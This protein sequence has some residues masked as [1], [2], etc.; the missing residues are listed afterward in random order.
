L[1][2]YHP[3]PIDTSGVQ[4]DASLL[5]LTE[6]LARN[7]HEVWAEG[8]IHQGWTLGEKRDD[9]ARTHPD[10]IPYESLRESEKDFDRRTAMETL[11]VILALGYRIER[12]K[13]DKRVGVSEPGE[14]AVADAAKL[15]LN[16]VIRY[17][18]LLDRGER[19]GWI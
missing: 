3:Q 2:K 10:L 16:S 12:P 14:N 13:G 18:Q 8:R 9:A 11:K 17:W 6:Y 1:D 5:E 19:H 4:L 7:T 15:S